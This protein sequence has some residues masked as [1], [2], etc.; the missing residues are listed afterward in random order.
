MA[1]GNYKINFSSVGNVTL[2]EVFGTGDMSPPEMTKKL[3]AFVKQ[4]NLGKK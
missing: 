2:S 1:F 4:N 3:W